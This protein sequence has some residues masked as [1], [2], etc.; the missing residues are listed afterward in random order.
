MH[1]DEHERASLGSLLQR[2]IGHLNSVIGEVDYK[3]AFELGSTPTEHEAVPHWSE[4]IL[5]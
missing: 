4:W 3:L 2:A 1:T 5:S